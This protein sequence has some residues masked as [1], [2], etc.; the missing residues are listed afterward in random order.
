[1]LLLLSRHGNTFEK[2]ETP[3]MVGAREDLPLTAEGEA[4][5]SR[6]FD[7]LQAV[8]VLPVATYSSQLQRTRRYAEIAVPVH[9][10]IQDLRLSEIDY[11]VWGGLTEEQI[12]A[13]GEG[14]ELDAWNK[15]SLWPQSPN[16]QPDEA[17]L[18]QNVRDFAE[19]LATKHAGETVL[20][21]SSNGVMRYFLGLVENALAARIADG[22]FKV[23]TGNLC[24]LRFE[25]G[26]WDILCW[27]EKPEVALLTGNA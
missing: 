5:A 21:V 23:K 4:Q 16:W 8:K 17:T 25:N 11:G 12:H 19:E 15:Q 6:L 3:T 7:A 9:V 10:P 13:R 22:T 1:M 18:R 14:D 26:L 20:V 24:I 2:G 27:N